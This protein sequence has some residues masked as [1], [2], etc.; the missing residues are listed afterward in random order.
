MKSVMISAKEKLC[1][2][3][4]VKCD[5]DHCVYAK[6]HFDRINDVVYELLTSRDITGPED[7]IEWAKEK[8]S[9]R[10]I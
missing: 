3:T 1:T 9:A 7:I 5:P 6:G 8:M 4:E 10:I 2:N